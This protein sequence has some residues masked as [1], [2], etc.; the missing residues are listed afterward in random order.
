M[1]GVDKQ[2][3]WV[4]VTSFRNT[5][6]YVLSSMESDKEKI[7]KEAGKGEEKLVVVV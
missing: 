1:G 2:H 3:I 7:F 6:L 5:N 4:S